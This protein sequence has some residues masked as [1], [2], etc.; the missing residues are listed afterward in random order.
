MS[1]L[2]HLGCSETLDEDVLL[3]IE[4]FVCRIYAPKSE[5]KTVSELRWA[6]FKKN[7]STSESLPPTR[8]A[9]RLAILR[10][11]YQYMIW[12][13]DIISNPL[14]PSSCECGWKWEEDKWIEVMMTK[15]PAPEAVLSLVKCNCDKTKCANNHCSCRKVKLNCTELCGCAAEEENCENREVDEDEEQNGDDDDEQKR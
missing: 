7:Q 5:L 4:E 1:A 10:A 14:I 6:M 3:K 8:D 11:H 12:A 15:P 13:N 2:A 9:L